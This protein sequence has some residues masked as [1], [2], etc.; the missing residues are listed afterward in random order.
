MNVELRKT[1]K[2]PEMHSVSSVPEFHITFCLS[3][4]KP[5]ALIFPLT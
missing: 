3:F 2:N 4:S 1:G 5:E